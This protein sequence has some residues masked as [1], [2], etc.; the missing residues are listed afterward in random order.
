MAHIAVIFLSVTTGLF[1]VLIGTIKLS[2]LV[3]EEIYRDMRKN[4]IRF[5]KVFP[6]ASITKFRPSPH[7]LRRV[8]GV[9]EVVNGLVLT[10]VPGPLKQVANIGL[11]LSCLFSI[12][13][14]YMVHDSLD[15][16]TSHLIFGL[17]LAC[18]FIVRLQVNARE[19]NDSN[20]KNVNLKNDRRQYDKVP[21]K[22]STINPEYDISAEENVQ[23]KKCD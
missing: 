14:H 3:N 12:Y 16:M 17:L 1:F 6:L 7:A 15:K 21:S 20:T 8:V 5:S 18:R 10:F 4:F 13:C 2:P 22:M 11:L 19:V 23:N 9:V